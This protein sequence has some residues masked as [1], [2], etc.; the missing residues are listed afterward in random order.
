MTK[1]VI[2]ESP[3]KA[4]TIGAYL[5]KDYVVL[6]S[7]GHV[8][9][10]PS[11]AAEIPKAVREE[12]WSRLGVDVESGFTPLYVLSPKRKDT[13]KQLKDAL[14]KADELYIATAKEAY[15][16][17]EASFAAFGIKAPK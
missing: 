17:F 5:P 9:D 3:T 8:R 10:L 15:K 6:A 4:R 12:P 13:I 16:P 2:V 1:L 14:K 11:S 7:M